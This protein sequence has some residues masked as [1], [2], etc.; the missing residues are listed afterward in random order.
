[1][2]K[3]NKDKMV[4]VAILIYPLTRLFFKIILANDIKMVI[5]VNYANI[6]KESTVTSSNPILT[7]PP[8]DRNF[9]KAAI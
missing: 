6:L 1:M 2:N 5:K 7:L 4:P 9:G 3:K 8:E